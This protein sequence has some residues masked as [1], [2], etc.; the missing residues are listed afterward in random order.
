MFSERSL[1]VPRSFPQEVLKDVVKL[2]K[3][4]QDADQKS[5]KKSKK[6]KLAPV[7]VESD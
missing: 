3:K 7:E 5:A 1:I 6:S 2:K 4:S